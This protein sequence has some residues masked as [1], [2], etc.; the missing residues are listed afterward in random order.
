MTTSHLITFSGVSRI[1]GTGAATVR[2]LD[3]VDL[4]IDDGEFVAV[5]GTQRIGQI[6]VHEYSGMPG[7]AHPGSVFL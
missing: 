4:Y 6:H 7:R 5:M 3:D 2:A 1:Y